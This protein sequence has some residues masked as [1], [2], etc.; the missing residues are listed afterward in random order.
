[1]EKLAGVELIVRIDQR[2]VV[3]LHGD[4]QHADMVAQPFSGQVAGSIHHQQG[5]LA[6]GRRVLHDRGLDGFGEG[7]EAAVIGG[8]DVEW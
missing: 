8:R 3:H 1:M 5:A 6:V 7:R 4:W 2:P